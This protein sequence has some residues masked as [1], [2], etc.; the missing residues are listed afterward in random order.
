MSTSIK[1][2]ILVLGASGFLGGFL[3]KDLASSGWD[4]RR[5]SSAQADLLR[6]DSTQ[7]L[8]S[9]A[10]SSLSVLFCAAVTRANADTEAALQDNLRIVDNVSRALRDRPIRQLVF[11][12]S[13]D[14]YGTRPPIPITETTATAPTTL[15]GKGKLAAEERLLRDLSAVPLSIL[16]LPGVYG[17]GDRNESVIGRLTRQLRKDGR[18]SLRGNP[19]VKRDYVPASFVAEIARRCLLDAR[20]RTLNVAAGRSL[21]LGEWARQV[22]DA[23]GIQAS[24]ET[25]PDPNPSSTGDLVFDVARLRL[26]FP[27]L[28]MPRPEESIQAYVQRN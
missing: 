7:R 17:P 12:S 18:V 13:A 28:T 10:S 23:M 1:P 3:A 27:D 16:R 21:G 19:A 24:V 26:L 14:V 15:Y 11:L 4:V 5:T 22:S 2:E 6:L 25:S 8:F 20:S 9:D